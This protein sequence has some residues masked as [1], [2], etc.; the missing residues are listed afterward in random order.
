[1]LRILSL[2]K[3]VWLELVMCI[4]ILPE[5]EGQGAREGEGRSKVCGPQLNF[6]M[7][8]VA[9]VGLEPLSQNVK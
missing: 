4:W 6:K 3:V 7:G 2:I 5:E 9:G 8:T 1:M